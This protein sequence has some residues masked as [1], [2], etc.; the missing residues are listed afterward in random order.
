MSIRRILR[1][2]LWAFL[3]VLPSVSAGRETHD[4]MIEP[5]RIVNLASPVTARIDKVLVNRGDRVSRDQVVVLLDANA[6]RA[7]ADLSK[8]K[9]GQTGPIALAESKVEFSQRKLV[10]K[11]EMSADNLIP[12]QEVD[13]AEAEYKAAASELQMAKDNREIAA[14]EHRQQSALL[15]L[16][17]LKSPL[18]GV[19][20]EQN[21]FPGEVVEPG[22]ERKAVLRLAQ[23]DPLRVNLILPKEL[24]GSLRAGDILEVIPEIPANHKYSGKIRTTDKLINAASGTFVVYLEIPNPKLEIPAGVACKAVVHGPSRAR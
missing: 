18:N 5:W 21:S 13:D 4:C 19:V 20:V 10:R 22:S 15:A 8:F 6:E 12:T 2:C 17:T 7:A 16:R 1:L 9:S 24:F 11:R 23:L 3:V 14:L